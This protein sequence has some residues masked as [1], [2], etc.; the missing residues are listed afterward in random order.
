MA[1]EPITV[2]IVEDDETAAKIY[3]QFTNKIEGF[4][5]IATASSGSQALELLN[6][7]TP[8]LILLDVFL[9]DINGIEFLWE[10]RRNHRGIDVIL[11]TAAN[12]VETVSAAIRGGAFSYIIKP[13]V[14]DKFLSTLKQY[15]FTREQLRDRKIMDQDRIDLLFGSMDPKS[16]IKE[17]EAP[18]YP[19]GI[20]KYTL[21]LIRDRVQAMTG[22]VNSDEMARL[23]GVSHS[24]V[25]RYLEYLV[26]K[27]EL[28]VEV[29]HGTVGRPERRYRL[30]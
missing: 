14:I 2:M 30:P 25:R 8:N 15:A 1:E 23:I 12:D 24:T 28:A 13:I 26:S 29:V 22:S 27:N 21:K 19:K 3:E 4:R 16:N 17:E 18:S 11:I 6:I 9:P 10:V 20:D 5:V 7:F